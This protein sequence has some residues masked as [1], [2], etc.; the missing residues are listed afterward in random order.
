MTFTKMKG[1]ARELGEMNIPLELEARPIRHRPYILN[2]V[3]K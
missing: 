3:Y 1:I 2:P